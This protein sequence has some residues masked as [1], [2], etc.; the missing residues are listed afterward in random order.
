MFMN[1]STGIQ[2]D[3]LYVI[4]GYEEATDLTLK[5]TLEDY[6]RTEIRRDRLCSNL[7]TLHEKGFVER[8][9]HDEPSYYALTDRGRR[10]IEARREWESKYF[11]PEEGTD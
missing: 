6:Y 3:L 4:A 8:I 2:R 1:V 5:R 10:E 9:D 11:D 7:D